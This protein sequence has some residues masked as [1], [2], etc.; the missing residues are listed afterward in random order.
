MDTPHPPDDLESSYAES[1]DRE[2]AAWQA[3]HS[4]PPGSPERARAWDAWSEAIMRTNRAW[5]KLNASRIGHPAHLSAAGA[6]ER[7]HA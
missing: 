3:L 5:R 1:V 4:H 2:R 6:A 7:P